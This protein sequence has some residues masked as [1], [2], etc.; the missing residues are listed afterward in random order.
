LPITSGVVADYGE[1]QTIQFDAVERAAIDLKDH[2]EVAVA[3]C[4]RRSHIGQNAGADVIA[5]ARFEVFAGHFPGWHDSPPVFAVP[6][7]Y[8]RIYT[9]HNSFREMQKGDQP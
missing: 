6:E 3:V 2:R 4:R 9:P 5:A 8:A 1:A 7:S